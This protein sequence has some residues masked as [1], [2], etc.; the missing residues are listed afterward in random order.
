MSCE[1]SRAFVSHSRSL[2]AALHGLAS[3]KP[4]VTSYSAGLPASNFL[5]SREAADFETS[6]QQ[7]S[8]SL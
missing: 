8:L 2:C 4:A 1:R 3:Q 5:T 6:A 7:R